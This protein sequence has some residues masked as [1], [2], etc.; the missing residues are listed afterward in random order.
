[1]ADFGRVPIR[2]RCSKLE[3]VVRQDTITLIRRP[4][5]CNPNIRPVYTVI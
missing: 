2:R 5:K 3:S 1:L 4:T